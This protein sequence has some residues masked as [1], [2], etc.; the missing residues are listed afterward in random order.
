MGCAQSVEAREVKSNS[1][2]KT[3]DPGHR[4]SNSVNAERDTTASG[5]HSTRYSPTI[6]DLQLEKERR[7]RLRAG[8]SAGFHTPVTTP[9]GSS[10]IVERVTMG[11]RGESAYSLRER[12][13][14]PSHLSQGMIPSWNQLQVHPGQPLSRN[15]SLSRSNSWTNNSQAS[16]CGL[17]L[18]SGSFLPTN[19]LYSPSSRVSMNGSAGHRR[20]ANS[21]SE[22]FYD[23]RS[24]RKSISFIDVSTRHRS[25]HACRRSQT[26]ISRFQ[27]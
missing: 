11:S 18:S 22:V 13:S 24:S 17:H 3:G 8:S 4:D 15:T 6:W 21:R 2:A 10:R 5:R 9:R 19:S 16:S 14:T 1:K 26:D 27:E 23:S 20:K 7:A 25:S 12:P